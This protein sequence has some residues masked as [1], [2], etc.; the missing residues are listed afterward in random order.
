[1][2]STVPGGE[3]LRSLIDV[4]RLC[5]SL[6]DLIR[7]PSVNPFG[8]RAL[9]PCGELDAADYLGR[10][11]AALGWQ[12]TLQEYDAR[13][14][15]LLATAPGSGT[16]RPGVVFAGHLD[17]VEV[18]DYADPFAGHLTEER[19]YGRGACD[20]KAALACYLEV[21]E[22][23]AELD[24]ELLGPLAIA[25]VADEEFRQEGAKNVARLLPETDLVVIGEPTE[26]RIC[27]ASKGLAAYTLRTEGVATH[28]SV[29][30]AGRNA[31]LQAA[32]L[33]LAVDRHAEELRA[34]EHPLLGP[35]VIN[36]GVV[37]GG[38]KPNVVPPSAELD[39]SRR[40]LPGETPP[41][42]RDQLHAA[43]ASELA[44]L[45]W[46]LSAAWWAVDPYE[47]G[48]AE[49]V[50]A[51]QSSAR[52]QDLENADTTGFL[53]SSDAAYFGPPVVIFGPGS[54]NQ[55]HSL[56]EWVPIS[57][58]VTATAVYLQFLLDRLTDGTGRPDQ[59]DP[60]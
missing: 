30:G 6:V 41:R 36:I 17:T 33:A 37:R 5:Q 29:P 13:R 21:A 26:L 7:I 47:N 54:L 25:G 60:S 3:G 23:L 58:M 40:L 34:T 59:K 10:R 15:N 56:D 20:M 31:I 39:L 57:D 22:V 2:V 24:V 43:L 19:V 46:D 16:E 44:H 50:S 1:M 27:S 53:A 38:S 9:G 8:A 14:A 42:A 52:R 4:D 32:R 45:D 12:Q 11:L 48:N 55:A 18:T 35:P 28:G 51:F 49:V